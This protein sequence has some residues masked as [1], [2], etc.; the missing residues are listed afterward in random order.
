ML[1]EDSFLEGS[2][3]VLESPFIKVNL[4]ISYSLMLFCISSDLLTVFLID[5]TS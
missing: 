3:V 4:H 1:L 5:I 2:H